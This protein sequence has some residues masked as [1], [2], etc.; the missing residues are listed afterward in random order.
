[1]EAALGQRPCQKWIS[2]EKPGKTVQK[3]GIW[4]SSSIF[5]PWMTTEASSDPFI[6]RGRKSQIETILDR[7]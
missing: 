3:Q 4:A 1:M 6:I 7:P 2:D 5:I